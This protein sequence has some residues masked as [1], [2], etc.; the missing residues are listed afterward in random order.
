MVE[1]GDL[2]VRSACRKLLLQPLNLLRIHVIA[3]ERKEADTRRERWLERVVPLAV[4]V[5]QLVHTL[6][7]IVVV[8]QGRVELDPGVEQRL[9]RPLELPGVVG[10]PLAAV[11]VVAEQ[12][13]EIE[14]ELRSERDDLCRDGRLA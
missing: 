4:H 8:A 5:E 13:A 12:N 3:V 14:G 6:I 2:P 1:E 11:Q 7:R 10:G 9:V